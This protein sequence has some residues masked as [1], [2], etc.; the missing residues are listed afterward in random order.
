MCE[1]SLSFLKDHALSQS[2]FI[3]KNK[4]KKE[5]ERKERKARKEKESHVLPLCDDRS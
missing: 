5:S 4:R 3:I 2:L 1:A